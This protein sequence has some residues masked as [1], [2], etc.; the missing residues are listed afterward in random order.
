MEEVTDHNQDTMND[1]MMLTVHHI[2]NDVTVLHHQRTIEIMM[3][4]EEVIIKVE[5]HIHDDP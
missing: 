3:H 2:H 1:H 4:Q 5:D